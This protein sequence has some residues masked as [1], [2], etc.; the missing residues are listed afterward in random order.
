MNIMKFKILFFL[1]N[2]FYIILNFL[3]K[4]FLELFVFDK[5]IRRL[6]K[7]RFCKW[8]LSNYI[9]RIE[10][11]NINLINNCSSYRIWQYWDTG[12][13]NAPDIVKVCMNSVSKYKGDLERVILNDSNIKDYVTIPEY[14]YKLKNKGIISKA[15][16]ADIL[17]TY[18][19]YYH[20]GCWIDATVLLTDYLPNYI[21][22]S[23]LF[24]FRANPEDDPDELN[25]TNY[26]ISSK[27][28]SI[29]IAKMK[30]FL[31]LYWKENFFTINYFFYMHAFTMFTQSSEENI[32]EF[33]T[34]FN[35]PYAVVQQMEK[36]LSNEYSEKR[37]SELKSMISVHKLSYKVDNI[38]KHKDKNINN[39]LYNYLIKR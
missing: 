38:F 4:T 13:E 20:G 22:F 23:E 2:Y 19:L 16:F 14:I 11:Q 34:V 27:G 12:I 9:K 21:K 31:D 18:L 36:E 37:F 6:L 29:L 39:S 33:S 35:V 32:K 17:R 26:L 1:H 25:M 5:K 24:V 8:F 3:V 10:S 28:S 7:G 30:A 15:H